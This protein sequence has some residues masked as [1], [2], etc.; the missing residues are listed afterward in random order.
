M[1]FV[2]F[3]PPPSLLLLLLIALIALFINLTN[4]YPGGSP[5]CEKNV[6]NHDTHKAQTGKSPFKLTIS[7][8]TKDKE[9]KSTVAVTITGT[10]NTKFK[11]F[12]LSANAVNS[13][14]KIGK[15]T[16]APKTKLLTCGASVS[17]FPFA[18]RISFV[19]SH[20]S[21]KI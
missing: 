15:F 9:G 8:A 1:G 4:A 18:F 17:H 3:P 14:D 20:I 5:K 11:G 16:K 7:P 13:N 12:Y 2:K 10:N 19:M 21:M 6:P